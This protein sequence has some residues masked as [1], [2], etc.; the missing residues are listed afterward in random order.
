MHYIYLDQ[1][2]STHNVTRIFIL[3]SHKS[4]VSDWHSEYVVTK[5]ILAAK[6]CRQ[7]DVCDK[8]VLYLL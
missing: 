7:F 4:H 3:T 8:S 1:I 6:Y 2:G 5:N